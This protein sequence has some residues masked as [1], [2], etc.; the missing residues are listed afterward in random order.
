MR[1]LNKTSQGFA[2]AE[3]VVAMVVFAVIALSVLGLYVTLIRSSALTKYRAVASALATSQMETLKSLPYNSLA[4]VGGSIYSTNLLP[5][6]SQQTI[7]G[8]SYTTTTSISYVDDAFDGCG[9]YPSAALKQLYCRNYPAPTGA[10]ATDTNP[11]DYKI[12]NVAVYG[13]NGDK[14]AEVDT[15][16]SARV[17]ETASTTG[18][19]FVKVID[20]NGNPVSG[21]NVQVINTTFT[22]A[23]NLSD[24]TD[25][26]GV[27]IFYGLPPDT[28]GYDY[29]VTASKED[30][31][32]LSTIIPSG[33]LQPNYPNQQVFTQLSSFVTLPIYPKSQKSILLE[34]TTVSGTPISNLRLYIKGGYK[35]YNSAAN[36][37]YYYD[38]MTPTDT[39]PQTDSAGLVAVDNLVPGAYIFC[40]DTG[41]T[42]CSVGGT[43]YYVAA[44]VPYSGVNSFNPILVPSDP[45]TLPATSFT[46]GGSN[47]LQKARVLLTTN[48]NF[49]RVKVLT[50]DD[51][52]LST[53]SLTV[54]TFKVTG[55]NLPCS[56]IASS[57]ATS[58]KM[59]Q[60][61][62]V[63]TAS[64]TGSSAGTTLDCT[65][66]ISGAAVGLM[67]LELSAGG[68]TLTIPAG[69]MMG[70]FS[71][72]L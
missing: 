36:T 3:L 11:Q 37:A 40:G 14:Y 25:S 43:T 47:Y 48:S 7:S 20:D 32:T 31:S 13:G 18:A 65:I 67:R 55:N 26:G 50:P 29:T 53:S 52:S 62:N 28:S 60:G 12:I 10:P 19:L 41:A 54:F 61:S 24:S 35:K 6:T 39:R 58:V 44:I 68:N 8:Y 63:Y 46:Y 16:V 23:V 22:P 27:A 70:G 45:G 30:Y 72:V 15:M 34:A 4:V 17:A 64:C 9:S 59:L 33:S 71:V 1:D 49:P 51:V 57:C 21:A 42:S 38:N 2:L 5:A 56:T 66:N 69:D